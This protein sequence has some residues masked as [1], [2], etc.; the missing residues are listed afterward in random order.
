[1]DSC[2]KH[3]F[4]D[5]QPYVC[6]FS[7]CDLSD[8]F[9]EN[10]DEWNKHEIQC[11]RIEWFCNVDPHPHYVEKADF[12]AHMKS[13][14]YTSFDDSQLSLLSGMF[15]CPSQRLDG[16]CNLC[17]KPSVRLETH[18]S[19]HLEQ[20]ALFALP[21]I[22]EE[23]G[24]NT[25]NANGSKHEKKQLKPTHLDSPTESS[26]STDTHE[27]QLEGSD[28]DDIVD[29]DII[30]DSEDPFWDMMAGTFSEARKELCLESLPSIIA[31]MCIDSHLSSTT[32]KAN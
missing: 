17:R 15:S 31:I 18:V 32:S 2:R 7:D 19:R 23:A 9:F 4:E 27:Q 29:Q 16:I 6:T 3:V 30:P 25:T 28:I 12:L 24:D 1:M 20:I 5:L 10:R 26:S 8:Q 13:S 11:H 21:R 14:H 22:N